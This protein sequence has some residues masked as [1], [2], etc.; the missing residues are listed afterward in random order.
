MFIPN[1]KRLSN[2]KKLDGLY[3]FVA[4]GFSNC[5]YEGTWTTSYKTNKIKRCNWGDYR[6]P[7]SSDLDEGC[8][9]F[10]PQKKYARFGWENYILCMAIPYDNDIERI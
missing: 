8:G 9:E 10:I 1:K 7:N 3:L 4:D 2:N 5:Q 6:I